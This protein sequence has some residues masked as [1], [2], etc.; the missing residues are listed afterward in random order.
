MKTKNLLFI[1]TLLFSFTLFAENV[2]IEKAKKVALN[3]YFEKYNQYEGQVKSDQL[4]IRTVYTETD[5]VQNFYYVFQ[6]NNKGFVIVPADDCLPP[7][8]GY[9]FEHEYVRENQPPNVQYWLGQYKD[10]V[11]YAKAYKLKAE[12]NTEARWSRY[13]SDN[14]QWNKNQRDES[15]GPLLTATWNQ[16][17]P[18]NYYCPYDSS[19]NQRTLVGCQST[20]LAQILYYW[21]WPKSGLGIT[22]WY[23]GSHPEYGLQVAGYENT[24]YRFQEMVDDPQTVNTAIGEL[25]Y[26][27]ASVFHTNFSV[28]ASQPDSIFILDNQSLCDTLSYHLKLLPGDFLYRDSMPD[29]DWREGLRA[30]L[31]AG[32]PV[33]YAGYRIYPTIGHFFVCDGYQDE[34][35]YHFNFGWGGVADGYYTLDNLHNYIYGQFRISTIFPDT[36]Q[37]EYPLYKSG[38]DT[39]RTLEG[40]ITDGSGPVNNYLNNTQASWLIDPQNEMDSVTSITITVKRLDL[41]EDGDRL[42]IYDGK[43]NSAPLLAELSGNNLPDELVSSGNK[44][45]VEF[46]TDGSQT[47]PGFYLTYHT[48]VPQFCSGQVVINDDIKRFDDGSGKFYYQN[49]NGCMWLLQPEG[50]DSALTLYFDYFKTEENDLLQIYDLETQEELAKYSGHYDEP[51]PAVVS[52]S[53]K[54]I[55]LFSTNSTGRDKGWSA[56]YGDF[57]GIE[58]QSEPIDFLMFPNPVHNT[59][60]ISWHSSGTTPATITVYNYL[61]QKTGHDIQLKTHA[62]SNK[63]TIDVSSFKSGIYFLQMMVDGK[64]VTKKFIKY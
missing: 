63:F 14:F 11:V 59:L 5:G 60:H 31:D 28:G 58:S 3:F 39:L 37:Y 48:E 22:S 55:L 40:S 52:P 47:A 49:G 54:M 20:A 50:C 36:L 16:D 45:F 23:C 10:Q 18:Y 43:D 51:P 61:G 57:T 30:Q 42:L 1:M 27:A 6:I 32:Y 53:G 34:E 12:E 41:F 26:H 44:V 29:A 4:S 19:L 21:G 7:V 62:G 35:Y 24:S 17:M 64:V 2:P 13:L 38:A 46:I 25:C 15:V 33:F 8:L 56:Y 9:S